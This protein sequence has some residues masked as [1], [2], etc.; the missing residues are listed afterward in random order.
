[1]NH[2]LLSFITMPNGLHID[3]KIKHRFLFFFFPF[4][5]FWWLPVERWHHG[6]PWN[7]CKGDRALQMMLLLL[8]QR[9][10]PISLSIRNPFFLPLFFPFVFLSSILK[11]CQLWSPFL[12]PI[13]RR[14]FIFWFY[15]IFF[16]IFVFVY[17]I[18]EETSI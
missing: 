3:C 5:R 7:L 2:K 15:F 9:M 1:M 4:L 17:I 11:W 16:L 10:K 14:I 18:F 6:Q 8:L 13:R 12:C